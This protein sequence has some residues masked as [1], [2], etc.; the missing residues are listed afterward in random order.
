MS[1]VK[2]IIAVI[3]IAAV[4]SVMFLLYNLNG[5]GNG[6]VKD[7]SALTNTKESNIKLENMV[8]D[9]ETLK[10]YNG[11]D[12]KSAYIAVD[13]I[14]YDITDQKFLPGRINRDLRPGRDATRL[15][16]KTPQIIEDIKM[17]PIVGVYE[18]ADRE[19]KEE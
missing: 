7:V 15:I 1:K 2:I 5:M 9:E 8:F 3:C 18:T 16:Q 14:V 10:E 19:N 17:L 12:G 6:N 11:A 4:G 13:G